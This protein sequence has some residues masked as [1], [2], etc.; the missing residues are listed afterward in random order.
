MHAPSVLNKVVIYKNFVDGVIVVAVD[1][2]Y[3]KINI[4]VCTI[5]VGSCTCK[6]LNG[7]PN[8]NL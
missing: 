5:T 8:V 6:S 4:S 7:K 3:P 1:K 2:F